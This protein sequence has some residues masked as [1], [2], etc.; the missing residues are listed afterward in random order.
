MT[1]LDHVDRTP[2]PAFDLLAYVESGTSGTQPGLSL[3][4]LSRRGYCR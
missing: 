4:R 2:D 3:L 1:V